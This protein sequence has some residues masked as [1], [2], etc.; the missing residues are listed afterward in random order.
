MLIFMRLLSGSIFVVK[1]VEPLLFSL[2][3]FKSSFTCAH[4][5]RRWFIRATNPHFIFLT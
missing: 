4:G 2:S 5:K 3:A 1:N